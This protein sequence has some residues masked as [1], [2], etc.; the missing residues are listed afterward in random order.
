MKMNSCFLSC[1]FLRIKK[2][3]FNK[4]FTGDSI[5]LFGSCTE[6]ERMEA[7]YVDYYRR[8]TRWQ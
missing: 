3:I 1:F 6:E 2:K 8:A 4:N 7:E 5:A